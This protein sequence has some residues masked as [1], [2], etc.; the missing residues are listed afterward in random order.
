M[1]KI[2]SL[3]IVMMAMMFAGCAQVDQT[4]RGLLFGIW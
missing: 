1:K 3:M 4:E 2:I